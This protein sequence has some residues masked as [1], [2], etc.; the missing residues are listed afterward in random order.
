[1]HSQGCC[2]LLIA[3]AS[4]ECSAPAAS[5]SSTAA[6]LACRRLMISNDLSVP[7]KAGVISEGNAC[8]RLRLLTGSQ[9]SLQKAW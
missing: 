3:A 8:W 5:D 2:M 4:S 6:R 9:V 7:L 1:M